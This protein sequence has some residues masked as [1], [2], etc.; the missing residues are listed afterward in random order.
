MPFGLSNAPRSFQST[1][2]KIFNGVKFVKIYL[3]DILIHSNNIKEHYLHLQ[4]V[5]NRL[6]FNNAIINFDKSKFCKHE[7][8]YH[9]YLINQHGISADLEGINTYTFKPPKTKREL[10]GIL[11][12][13][14]WY[15]PFIKNMPE[16]LYTMYNK[17]QN[18]EWN[19][20]DNQ[21]IINMIE[22][23][24]KETLLYYSDPNKPFNYTQMHQT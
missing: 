20:N 17:I 16:K 1:M 14:N 5:F 10:Q 23:I 6:H 22:E 24:K 21:L 7:V 13:L 18:F 12:L 9:G 3:E 8:K 11:G 15:M 2:N 4:D 19:K